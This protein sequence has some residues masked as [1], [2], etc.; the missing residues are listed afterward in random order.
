MLSIGLVGMKLQ[1]Q[2]NG[3]REGPPKTISITTVPNMRSQGEEAL[4]AQSQGFQ[5]QW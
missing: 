3:D 1:W 2:N 5:Q 4:V